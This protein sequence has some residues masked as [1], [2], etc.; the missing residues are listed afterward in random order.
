MI[1]RAPSNLSN[2]MSVEKMKAA[3]E[4]GLKGRYK[5]LCNRRS[6]LAPGPEYYNRYTHA[7][8]CKACADLINHASPATPSDSEDL[9]IHE[10][11][12]LLSK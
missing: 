6:C 12:R 9:C 11:I 5:G 2:A 10:T 7:Y 3:D 4:S 1:L 8:Y